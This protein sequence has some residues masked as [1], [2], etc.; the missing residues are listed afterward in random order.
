MWDFA[1]LGF[2]GAVDHA[3]RTAELHPN[4]HLSGWVVVVSLLFGTTFR[5]SAKVMPA[6]QNQSMS[7]SS[8]ALLRVVAP[9]G[10]CRPK[11]GTA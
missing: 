5:P 9:G 10:T 8:M 2:L 11:H 6:K 3:G 7:S 4:G 1:G